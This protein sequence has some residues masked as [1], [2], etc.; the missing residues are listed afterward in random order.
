MYRFRCAVKGGAIAHHCAGKGCAM[1]AVA[2]R[3][4]PLRKERAQWANCHCAPLRVSLMAFAVPNGNRGA[5]AHPP[6]VHAAGRSSARATW[7]AS[8]AA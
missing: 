5:I 1:V 8:S 2:Y 7:P 6:R 3:Q 4:L